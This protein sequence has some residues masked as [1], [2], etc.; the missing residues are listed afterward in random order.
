MFLRAPAGPWGRPLVPCDSPKALT[1]SLDHECID[2]GWTEWQGRHVVLNF[3]VKWFR[4]QGSNPV[5]AAPMAESDRPFQTFLSAAGSSRPFGCPLKTVSRPVAFGALPPAG[6]T[7][8]FPSAL[9]SGEGVRLMPD[10]A[11]SSNARAR[12]RRDA[13][14]GA[15]SPGSGT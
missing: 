13:V 2:R 15:P 10:V 3:P 9:A 14:V 1:H 5:V 4:A 12:I 6:A 7:E 11:E 8:L